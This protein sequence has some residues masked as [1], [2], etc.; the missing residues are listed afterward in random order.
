MIKSI[1]YFQSTSLEV[2]QLYVNILVYFDLKVISY[3]FCLDVEVLDGRCFSSCMR[4]ID[5]GAAL[6]FICSV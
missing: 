4:T 1:L 3:C 6:L 2:K 5:S